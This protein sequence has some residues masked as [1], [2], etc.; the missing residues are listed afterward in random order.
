MKIIKIW[1]NYLKYVFDFKR[2][3]CRNSKCLLFDRFLCFQSLIEYFG[4]NFHQA[5]KRSNIFFFF[6]FESE[7]QKLFEE[8]RF[9]GYVFC[10]D[11]LNITHGQFITERKSWKGNG[12]LRIHIA[13]IHY[14]Q[15][16]FL[17]QSFWNTH[18]H[19]IHT[20]TKTHTKKT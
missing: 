20:T 13:N 4:T 17:T 3:V 1:K 8:Q 11:Y 2:I 6:F 10:L 18:I 19:V 9:G 5:E 15:S 16:S 12:K 7:N 14:T